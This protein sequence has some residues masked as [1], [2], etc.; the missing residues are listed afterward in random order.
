MAG[1]A[2]PALAQQEAAVAVDTI[3]MMQKEMTKSLEE[4]FAIHSKILD[5]KKEHGFTDVVA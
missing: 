3:M 4:E 5:L 1:L 2:A